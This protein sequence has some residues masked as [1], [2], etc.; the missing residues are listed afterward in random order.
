MNLRTV[1]LAVFCL[2]TAAAAPVSAQ[3]MIGLT[4]SGEIYAVDS[5]TGASTLLGA[6]LYGHTCMARDDAGVLWTVSRTFLGPQQFFLTRLDPST[7]NL[8]IVANCHA[9]LALADAGNGAVY[10]VESAPGANQLVRL[11]TSTGARTVI[12]S[13]GEN[14]TGMTSFQGL[15]YAWGHNSGL[16]TI[17]TD[18]GVFT[19]VGVGSGATDVQWLAVRPDGALIG[20]ADSFYTFDPTTGVPTLYAQGNPYLH[21]AEATGMLIPYGSG[22]Q[23]VQLAGSGTLLPGSLLITRSTGYPPGG[24]VVGIGGALIFGTSRTSFAGVPLPYDLDPMFGTNGCSLWAS[25]DSAA[26]GYTTGGTAPSLF[27]PIQIPATIANQTFYLQHAAFH[28][29]GATYWSNGL[30][31]HV[32]S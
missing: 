7:L 28:I 19:D 32:G 29:T 20:G 15:L 14:I 30:Q 4:F 23:G 24:S 27:F 10:G 8:Q 21:G 6:G 2:V 16:G 11:D 18:T 26:L 31:L 22:C 17:N 13:T 12:G 5:M 25:I 1:P 3:D 9:M